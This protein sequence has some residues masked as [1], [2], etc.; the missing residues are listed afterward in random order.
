[1]VSSSGALQRWRRRRA[2]HD[3]GKVMLDVALA[4]ALGGDYLADL[5]VV[6]AQPKRV[7]AVVSDP[8][9]SRLIESLAAEAD[10]AIAAIRVARRRSSR[11]GVGAQLTGRRRPARPGSRRAS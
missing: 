4:I 9:V 7:G 11:D 3:S 8:T 2:E 5:A 6:R 1:L 10:A